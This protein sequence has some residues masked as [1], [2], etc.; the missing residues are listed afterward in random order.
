MSPKNHPRSNSVA[1]SIPSGPEF[2]R[3]QQI[4]ANYGLS[5]S[6]IFNK[7][8][9][10]TFESILV[11]HPGAKRGIRLVKVDSIR[12]YLSSFEGANEAHWQTAVLEI[13]PG[14]GVVKRG[15]ISL[16]G[17]PGTLASWSC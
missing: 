13:K 10:G 17:L 7:L 2:S 6:H 15:T 5:R 14:I 9:D 12:R 4:T 16:R 1:E 11:K 8:H 3:I